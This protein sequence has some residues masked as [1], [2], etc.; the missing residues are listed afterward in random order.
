MCELAGLVCAI[1]SP[2]RTETSPRH[3][4][5]DF[6]GAG[7]DGGRHG[8]AERLGGVEIDDQLECRRLLDG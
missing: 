4:L 6:V 5:D 7:E 1:G 8:Q 2:A 3:S